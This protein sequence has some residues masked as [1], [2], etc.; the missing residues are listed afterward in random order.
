MGGRGGVGVM[1]RKCGSDCAR[2]KLA[3]AVLGAPG[4]AG[5]I[6]GALRQW[7]AY[8]MFVRFRSVV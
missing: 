1:G 7:V 4:E 2:S 5:A 3:E 6:A 8:W